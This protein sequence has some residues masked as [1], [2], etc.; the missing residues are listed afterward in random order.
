MIMLRDNVRCAKA[1]NRGNI[2]EATSEALPHTAIWAALRTRG[3]LVRLL[4]M[5]TGEVSTS[6]NTGNDVA[7]PVLELKRVVVGESGDSGDVV[8]QC[9]EPMCVVVSIQEGGG[10][11]RGSACRS[12][13]RSARSHHHPQR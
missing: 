11:R 12:K 9:T 1:T 13:S 6:T 3:D 4:D 8:S 10:L 2:K 5:K 7:D